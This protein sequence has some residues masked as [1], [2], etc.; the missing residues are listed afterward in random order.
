[1]NEYLDLKKI[2]YFFLRRWVWFLVSFAICGLLAVF[3]LIA[4]PQFYEI[5]L[6]ALVE[7]PHRISDPNR[8]VVG[9]QRFNEPD[10]YYFVNERAKIKTYP[11]V[12]Q[13]VTN[14]D[15]SKKYF[16]L[17][18]LPK[19]V[20]KD[21]PFTVVLKNTTKK[22]EIPY[23]LP[24][25]FIF[26]ENN[27]W[28]MEID[29]EY[30]LKNEAIEIQ[31]EKEIHFNE[32]INVGQ[33]EFKLVPEAPSEKLEAGELFFFTFHRTHDV[34]LELMDAIEVAAVENDASIFD[35][36]I[37]GAPKDKLIAFMDALGKAYVQHHLDEKIAVLDTSISFMD[38]QITSVMKKM[39]VDEQ[40]IQSYKTQQGLT[41]LLAEEKNV[42]ESSVALNKQRSD[43]L[44]QKK[45]AD[46]LLEQLE[47]KSIDE[48]VFLPNTFGTND[49]MLRDLVQEYLDLEIKK[50]TLEEEKRT[51]HPIYKQLPAKIARS[52]K[53]IRESISNLQTSLNF[54]LKE[55]ERSLNSYNSKTYNLPT[56]ELGLTRLQ[57][58]LKLDEE[59][60]THL[61]QKRS[62]AY[63]NRS[64]IA[65]DVR[66]VQPAF[67]T[68]SDPVFPNLPILAVL[69]VL[70]GL[71]APIGI[72]IIKA[73]FNQ[74][75]QS[76]SDVI[77]V[78]ENALVAEMSL[79]AIQSP[80]ELIQYPDSNLRKELTLLAHQ[81]SN[82]HEQFKVLNILSARNGDGKYWLSG[83]LASYYVSFA[84]DKTVL[85]DLN[86]PNEWQNLLGLSPGEEFPS[87]KV[88]DVDSIQGLSYISLPDIDSEKGTYEHTIE[89]ILNDLQTKF[90]RII[91]NSKSI[92]D[93]AEAV[94]ISAICDLNLFVSRKGKS[95]FTDLEQSQLLSDN[96]S[97]IHILNAQ[98]PSPK[99][100]WKKADRS[101]NK[102]FGFLTKIKLLFMNR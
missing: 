25:N 12:E 54:E 21:R 96:C 76:L 52:K 97:V 38:K 16:S 53:R 56:S 44:A 78:N 89:S 2:V 45:Y 47:K 35:V 3:A 22:H 9:E 33:A 31:L 88:I 90:D 69:V 1:M 82:E 62:E 84:G 40:K 57:R 14:L 43:L 72:Y 101:R 37:M 68:S 61:K 20:Y 71:I 17:E 50:K 98:I 51:N 30:E 28:K 80:L 65:P 10:K 99:Y 95:S 48:T 55:V 59:L 29:G 93:S 74:R 67:A 36:S 23:E 15:L 75:I 18:L 41:D 27:S 79:N 66:I 94:S 4:L 100:N 8:L 92:K 83:M 73:I 58:Q 39:Q 26:L 64:V 85:V 63:L 7:E 11:L 42:I 24:I 5:K 19:E 13:V 77:R 70:L 81:I 6:S 87:N 91:I 86:A 49:V 32:W 60:Y 102:S 46:F 34:V